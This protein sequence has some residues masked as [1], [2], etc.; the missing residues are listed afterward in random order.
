MLRNHQIRGFPK[1]ANKHLLILAT[2]V[3]ALEL[4]MA[5]GGFIS[6]MAASELKPLT[7]HV[8]AIVGQIAPSGRLPL[9]NRLDL[10]I[11]LSWRN[12]AGLHDFLGRL[13]SPGSPEFHHYVTPQQFSAAFSPTEGDYQAA[14]NFAKTN[15]LEIVRIHPNRMLLDVSGSVSN[16]ENAFRVKMQ[17]FQHPKEARE[18][19]APDVEPSIDR[20]IRIVHV[21]GLDNYR[22]PKPMSRHMDTTSVS[23]VIKRAGSGPNGSYLGGD[24][25]AAY[26]AGVSLTGTGQA[27]GL[28]EFDGYFN[29]DIASYEAQAGLPDVP[30]LNVLIDGFNGVPTS[31]R[32]GSNNEEVALDID[33]AICM[34]PGLS[35]VVVYEASPN[36]TAAQTDDMI[37]RMAEDNIASQLS[38][39]WGFDIDIT[40]QQVFQQMAAQGQSFFVASGDN[41]AFTAFVDQPTDNPYITA[42]GGTTL[43]TDN[44]HNWSSEVA[45]NGSGGGISSVYALPDWQIGIATPANGGSSLMRNV[46]DVAMVAENAWV[47]ADN[48]SSFAIQGTSMATPL[49]AAFTALVN[50][51]GA[52]NGNP[53][54]GFLN[55][56]LYAIG[57]S[58]GYTQSFHDVTTGNNTNP[59]SKNQ[60][61]ATQGYDLCTGWGTPNGGTNLINALTAPPLEPL[62]ISPPVGFI[63]AGPSGGPFANPTQTYILTNLGGAPIAWSLSNTSAWLDVSIESGTLTPG[64]PATSLTVTIDSSAAANFLL[65]HYTS[66]ILVSNS[67]DGA[68]FER[69]VVLDIGNGGFESGDFSDWSFSG[70]SLYS[71]VDS[72]DSTDLFGSTLSGVNDYLFVHSGIYG[73]FLGQTQSLAYLSQTI[74]TTQGA[75]YLLSFWLDNPKPGTPN[76]FTVSWNGTSLYDGV[77]LGQFSWTNMIFVLTADGASAPLQFGS[78]NDQ[79]AFGLDD[80]TILPLPAPILTVTGVS[81][82]NLQLK[83]SAVPGVT[84]L[85]QYTED[86]ER[87]SWA[88]LEDPV[89]A[90]GNSITTSDLISASN[91]FYRALV[92]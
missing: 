7:G 60:F 39:S 30:L 75:R 76:E 8:P 84:Y 26:V 35:Q 56:A 1:F 41:G 6:E 31:S 45:W 43:T 80:I 79:V 21:S 42:V 3:L 27:V 23:R 92:H 52:A 81:N 61:F 14:I 90:T 44:A 11:A 38:C 10:A 9:T 68:V 34:A 62:S 22:R 89:T 37:S 55:P 28:L 77:D 48:G 5:I 58:P 70:Q 4:F 20:G 51:Q 50:Q 46:P 53:P 33:M 29:A 24:F 49:W 36:A 54:V 88:D 91:R 86:L 16:I 83:W 25:R 18:F 73:A 12:P 78:R 47:W 32:A 87:D 82:G 72:V 13:Y 66:T 40:S 19:F 17:L 63:A 57:K 85:I 2:R 71:F 59:D 69:T 74:P 15:G 67:T 64:G 65:G